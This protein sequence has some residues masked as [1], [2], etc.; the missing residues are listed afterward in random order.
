MNQ[1]EDIGAG[2][3]SGLCAGYTMIEIKSFWKHQQE[4]CLRWL[5]MFDEFMRNWCRRM[6]LDSWKSPLDLLAGWHPCLRKQE[7]AG[8]AHGG[9]RVCCGC[10]GGGGL[11]SQLP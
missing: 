10:V 8:M 11:A 2:R 1:H 7:G 6:H 4:H 3:A 9:L 5:E